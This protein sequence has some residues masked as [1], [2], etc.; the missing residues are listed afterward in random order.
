MVSIDQTRKHLLSRGHHVLALAGMALLALGLA[1]PH[2]ETMGPPSGQM[3]E[4][5]PEFA[6]NLLKDPDVIF[7]PVIR[8]GAPPEVR[9][10]E[11]KAEDSGH[12]TPSADAL[13]FTGACN[14]EAECEQHTGKDYVEVTG[15]V[16]IEALGASP[17]DPITEVIPAVIIKV[18]N[19]SCWWSC[20]GSN[21]DCVC[22]PAQSPPRCPRL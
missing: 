9:T 12:Y 4:V 15:R 22:A 11:N 14:G 16:S 21:C 19:E 17:D 5:D 20:S 18:G 7:I 13:H 6:D 8:S 1:Q 10:G 3:P 2:A